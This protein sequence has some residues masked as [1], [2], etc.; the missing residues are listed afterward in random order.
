[1]NNKL[2]R[3]QGLN[4]Q[5]AVAHSVELIFVSKYSESNDEHKH[6]WLDQNG[7]EYRTAILMRRDG[8]LLSATLNIAKARDGRQ[9]LYDINKIKT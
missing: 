8:T 7:W 9:I 1:M 3:K 5:L 4:E 6:Q 2:S